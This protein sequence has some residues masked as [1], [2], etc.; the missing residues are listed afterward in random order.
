MMGAEAQRSLP[1][2]LSRHTALFSGMFCNC[3]CTNSDVTE[4]N[5]KE[6]I[7]GVSGGMTGGAGVSLIASSCPMDVQ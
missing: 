1:G 2:S 4:G 6:G 3:F 7:S 5:V